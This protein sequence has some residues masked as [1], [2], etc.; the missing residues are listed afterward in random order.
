MYRNR[1]KNNKK[2]LT[3]E[4]QKWVNERDYQSSN[5]GDYLLYNSY[6]FYVFYD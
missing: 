5:N 6:D 4:Y 3:C 1:I 2:M